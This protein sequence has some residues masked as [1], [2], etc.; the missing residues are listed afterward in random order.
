MLM[1]QWELAVLRVRLDLSRREAMVA[2]ELV[3]FASG[4]ERRHWAREDR[5]ETYGLD[6]GAQPPRRLRLPPDLGRQLAAS[7]QHDLRGEAALW[8]RLVP[9]YGYLGAVPWEDMVDV[10]GVPLLR[11]PD[12][13][14]VPADFGRTWTVA[15]AVNAAGRDWGAEHVRSL[16]SALVEELG[17]AVEMDVFADLVTVDLLNGGGFADTRLRVHPPSRARAAHDERTQRGVTQFRLPETSSAPPLPM[18]N[19]LWADWIADGLA[20]RAV[21][22]LHLVSDATF[23]DGRPLLTMNAD[24][25]EPWNRSTCGFA[26]GDDLAR[27]AD[28]LG[29]SLLSIGSPPRNTSDTATRMMVDT[30][31]QTRPGPTLYSRLG[32]DPG[33]RALAAAHGFLADDGGWS[34]IPQHQSLFGYVQPASVQRVIG[35][36]SMAVTADPQWSGVIAAAAASTPPVSGLSSSVPSSSG[37]ADSYRWAETVPTWVA[38][39]SRFLETQIAQLGQVDDPPELTAPSRLAY[40]IGAHTALDEIS[41]LVNRHGIGT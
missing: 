13:L 37:L 32:R 38:A 40:D 8:L 12:R 20:G 31:G 36:G 26:V 27:L 21:R 6:S 3:D 34:R 41:D 28:A 7:L 10:I 30:I 25:A 2:S 39:S 14:P 5:L 24:P 9:P 19:L 11:V 29:A 35:P 15:V 22:A 1:K 18:A 4:T 23:V 17:G 33:A 16:F